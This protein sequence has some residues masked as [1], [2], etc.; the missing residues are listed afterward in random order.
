MNR[1]WKMSTSDE[2]NSRLH[3]TL[4]H[5]RTVIAT[6]WAR[7]NA[8]RWFRPRLL[9]DVGLLG[10]I[11]VIHSIIGRSF[12]Y[13]ALKFDEQL[14]LFEGFSLGKGLV[15]YREFQELKP[16]ML[17]VINMLALKIFGFGGMRFRHFFALFTLVAFLSVTIALLSRRVPRLLI[18]I[19]VALMISHF[20]DH[21]LFDG[22][23]DTAE[24]VGLSFFLLAVGTLLLRTSWV[25]AQQI[26]GGVL[27]ALVPL[28]KEP[29]VFPTLLVWLS[30]LALHHTEAGDPRAW[31]IF[32]KRTACG[33]VGVGLVWLLYML[34]TRSF[35]SYLTQLKQIVTYSTE[36]NV[37]YGVFP[38]LS[39]GGTLAE[40]WR[41]I[42][43][44]Y[45]NDAHLILFYPF[46]LAALFLWRR[47]GKLLAASALATFFGGLY[48]VTIGR[49]FFPHYFIM[50]MTGT[51]FWAILGAIALGERFAEMAAPWRWWVVALVGLLA[52]SS[53]K[54]RLEQDW[55]AWGTYHPQPPPVPEALIRVVNQ[56]T[57][58]NDRIWNVGMPLLCVI[59]DRLN[60]SS[61]P[62]MHDSIIHLY[63]GATDAERFA[64]YRREL[65]R[66]MP[67]LIILSQ[68]GAI[69]GCDRYMK[70]LVQPFLQ[71]HHYRA[72]RDPAIPTIALYERPN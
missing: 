27:L 39:F 43:K 47:R 48:A 35:G 49:G 57:G 66:T 64:P 26:T 8:Q 10:A 69:C 51:F 37:M 65:D 68:T 11:T 16:P 41:R 70:T 34:V 55:N 67:K 20:Y 58:P 24:T 45:V 28:S 7:G 6:V 63:A 13:T 22:S 31:R 72:F 59:T 50:A 42:E 46:F 3:A 19:L 15:P 61:I 12:L 14:F 25:K 9:A 4:A 60:G 44:R 5:A 53:L 32:A 1:S 30:L 38:K 71:D 33:A 17:F 40:F 52:L 23:I 56:K 29:F 21:G 18:L 62:Y 2:A 54:P 36:H